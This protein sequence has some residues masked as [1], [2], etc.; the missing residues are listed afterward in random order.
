MISRT[1]NF[2]RSRLKI[3]NVADPS[4]RNFQGTASYWEDRYRHEGTSG[5][6]S[7]GPFARTKAGFINDFIQK[8][9]VGSVVDFG[10]GDGN[11]LR[12]LRIPRYVGLDVS[13][14]A[15][16]RLREQFAEDSSKRFV[17]CN[18]VPV[19][20]DTSLHADLGLSM[21]VIYHLIE[22]D[23]YER[24]M[25]DL[26][27]CAQKH[28]IIYSSDREQPKHV[29]R[30]VRHRNFTAFVESNIP[31]WTLAEVHRNPFRFLSYSSFFVFRADS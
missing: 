23:V 28:V 18:G 4:T 16:A 7:Y 6:G 17:Q 10:A 27:R 5:M 11:Q 8:H 26:F 31:G 22:D 15:I 19:S 14:T 20:D 9:R 25:R 3:F 1:A 21:D 29:S 2:I 13:E 24:Y 30:H 12:M